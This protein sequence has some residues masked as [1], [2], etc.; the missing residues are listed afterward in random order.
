MRCFRCLAGDE[1]YEQVRLTLDAAWG[2]PNA[3]TKTITCI[4]P[5]T[6]APRDTQGR[7][8]LA[9][10]EEFCGY[11]VANEMLPALLS[12]GVIEEITLQEYLASLVPPPS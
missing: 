8:M 10:T 5:A 12:D 2:H 1:T 4:D 3:E 11:S 6:V 9:T 7:I